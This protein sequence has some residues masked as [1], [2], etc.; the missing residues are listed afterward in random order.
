[1]IKEINKRVTRNRLTIEIETKLKKF[2][3]HKRKVL[4]DEEV[5]AIANEDHEVVKL[6]SRPG[7][8]VGNYTNSNTK[9]RG[10]WIFEIKVKKPSTKTSLR[11][12]IS[13]ITKDLNATSN[14][15]E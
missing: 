5:F 6:V 8:E 10:V 2:F 11:G 14:E 13:K 15:Q 12:K 9:Q 1:M 7:Y 3:S 4:T